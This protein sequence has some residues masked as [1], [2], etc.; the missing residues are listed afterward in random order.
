MAREAGR[1]IGS[2]LSQSSFFEKDIS[3][4][5]DFKGQDIIS[6]EQFDK[7][8]VEILFHEVEGMEELLRAKARKSDLSG[9]ILAT[10]FYEPSTRTRLSFE[11]AMLRLGG[12]VVSESS[13]VFSSVTAGERIEDTI[14]VVG[15]YADV[16]ALRDKKQGIAKQAALIADVPII[17]AGDGVGQHPTQSLIDL[18]TIQK[19]LGRLD[20][21]TI[22]LF[23]DLKHGRTIHSLSYLLSLFPHIDLHFIAPEVLKLPEGITQYLTEKLIPFSQNYKLDKKAF[24]SDVI[25]TTRVQ[26]ERIKERLGP[27]SGTDTSICAHLD[28]DYRLPTDFCDKSSALIMH[29]LPRINEIPPEIDKHPKAAYFRQAHNGVPVRMALIKLVLQGN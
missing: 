23:G 4:L 25:Y 13:V 22:T 14:K 26:T 19:E 3:P 21:L 27:Y 9:S 12:G 5:R 6:A 8:S 28:G 24:S 18:Y 20:H 11:V 10:L 2:N 16:I 29:P 15:G 1:E 7:K 17:N